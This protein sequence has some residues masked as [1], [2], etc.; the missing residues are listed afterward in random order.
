MTVTIQTDES[1]EMLRISVND[2][3]VFEGNFWD[4]NIHSTLPSVLTAA[5]LEVKEEGY[6]YE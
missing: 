3:L 2:K 4:F 5:G 1:C 6:D